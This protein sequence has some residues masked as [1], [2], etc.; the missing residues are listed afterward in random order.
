MRD[1]HLAP[2]LQAALATALERAGEIVSLR[3]KLTRY[4]ASNP[5]RGIVDD[6]E[7]ELRKLRAVVAA[8][9]RVIRFDVPDGPERARLMQAFHA[10]AREVDATAIADDTDDEGGGA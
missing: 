9:E 7:R 3:R 8:Y 6:C 4:H 2:R 5:H 10:R 1:E